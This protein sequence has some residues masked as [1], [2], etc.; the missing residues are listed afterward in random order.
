MFTKCEKVAL[1]IAGIELLVVVIGFRQ[2]RK[3]V[4]ENAIKKT[5]EQHIRDIELANSM[6]KTE[7]LK[8]IDEIVKEMEA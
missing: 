3:H 5:M 6:A 1:V 4:V 7:S 2:I 8:R